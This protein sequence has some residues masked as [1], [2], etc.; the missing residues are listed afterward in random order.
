MI[1]ENINLSPSIPNES[2]VLFDAFTI[3][4]TVSFESTAESDPILRLPV[5][6]KAFD[7]PT[8]STI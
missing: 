3:S 8:G 1:N 7:L 6:E 2:F 5:I 4:L